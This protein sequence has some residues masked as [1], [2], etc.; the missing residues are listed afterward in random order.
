MHGIIFVKLK[1]YVEEKLGKPAWKQLQ[2][3]AG[4]KNKIYMPIK[5]YPDEEM[6]ALISSAVELTRQPLPDILEDFG[7]YVVPDLVKMYKSLIKPEWKT[8]DLLEHVENTIHK[9][10][11]ITNPNSTPPQ[12]ICHRVNPR[13]VQ[14]IYSSARKMC[15][16]A[17]GIIQGIADLYH[18]PIRITEHQCMLSGAESCHIHVTLV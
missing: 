5:V 4:L 11:R 18:E 17:R 9:V 2:E 10:V 7:K 12:L 14:I 8:L 13:E 1:K 6:F 3:H 16:F 15:P